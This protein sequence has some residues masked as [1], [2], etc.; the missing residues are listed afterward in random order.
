M[1]KLSHGTIMKLKN[2][3]AIQPNLVY[4]GD[5]VLKTIAEAN[6][7]LAET[8]IEEK[9][10]TPFGLYDLNEFLSVLDLVDNPE[11][12]FAEDHAAIRDG[13]TYIK[14]V[15]ANPMILTAPTKEIAMPDADVVINITQK[16]ID[17]IRRAASVL[18]YST[19]AIS[20]DPGKGEHR[21]KLTVEVER[22]ASGNIYSIEKDIVG[23]EPFNFKFQ[24]GNIKILPGDYEVHLSS[25][26]ISKWVGPDATYWIALELNST[27]GAQ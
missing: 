4:K 21:V 16:D 5:G 23:K 18:K 14:Y 9:I 11:I 15:F 6:N 19:F 7:I 2:F 22:G 17:Q 12:E 1:I 25:K 20:C 8:L 10:E 27:Y 13:K 24:I 3:A 26:K